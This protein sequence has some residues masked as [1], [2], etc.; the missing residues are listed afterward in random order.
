VRN[1]LTEL[2]ISLYSQA[3]DIICISETW[4]RVDFSDSL[5]DP[6]GEFTIFRK[7]RLSRDGGGVCIFVRRSLVSVVI[8]IRDA[9][10]SEVEIIGCS[11][12]VSGVGVKDSV[13][14]DV[15]CIYLPPNIS[16]ELFN[17]T[18]TYLRVVWNI[19]HTSL[20]TGDIN[21]PDFKWSP[22]HVPGG[23]RYQALH[24]V[25]TDLGCYQLNLNPTRGNNILD[26]L[27]CDEPIIVSNLV[28]T[29]PF[30]NSDHDCLEFTIILV[31]PTNNLATNSGLM[32]STLDWPKTDWNAFRMYCYN[33]SWASL[34]SCGSSNEC[35]SSFYN[36]LLAGVDQFVPTKWRTV[37]PVP[38][39]YRV[40]R[41]VR[42]LRI[43]KVLLWRAYRSNPSIDNLCKLKRCQALITLTINKDARAYEAKIIRS[44]SLTKFYKHVSSRL[45]HKSGIAPLRA[46]DG[47]LVMD[48]S[49]K[50]DILNMHFVSVGTV[51]NGLLPFLPNVTTPG[52][53]F[54]SVYF[55]DNII[56][57]IINKLKS[58]STPGPDGLS[59]RLLKNL[60]PVICG[61]L[62]M[63]FSLIANYG[64]IPDAWKA[65]TVIPIFKKGASSDPNN[66]RPISLTSVFCKVFESVLKSQ[67][68]DYLGYHSFINVAQ[69]GFLAKHS[70]TT[71]LLET[72]NDWTKLL[73]AK[74]IVKI[75]Y[76]DFAKAF[77]TVSIPKLLYKLDRYGVC[78]SALSLIKS[79]L[80]DRT[81]SVR[82][83]DCHSCKLTVANGCPQGSVLGPLLFTIFINDLPS[84]FKPDFKAKL[85]ADDLK[86]YS[87][88]DY[89]NN[90]AVA[91]CSL[92][93]VYAWSNEWQLQLALA[94]C[95]SMVLSRG[96]FEDDVNVLTIAGQPFASMDLVKDLGVFV[97]PKLSF[98]DH[99][100]TVI[101]KS[102]Q[103]IYLLFKCF[104]SRNID[105]MML[106]YTTY[107]LPLLEYCSPIWHPHK[108]ADIDRLEDV[109]RYFTK[110]LCGLW[111]VPYV[112]RLRRCGLQSLELRRTISDLVLC[113]KI[114]HKLIALNI[115]DFFV[116]DTNSV[117]RGHCFKMRIPLCSTNLR[118]TS[119]A[120]RVLPIWNALPAALV[121]P[122]NLSKFKR[123]LCIINL[124]QFLFRHHDV[125]ALT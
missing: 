40:S 111:D 96:A 24:Q 68:L 101:S 122:V 48:D 39:K 73:D 50:A 65:A 103:R 105:L 79:F 112:D 15:F 32:R 19:T 2:Y 20:I 106:A 59:A 72:T 14:L 109:Q 110:R 84:I 64:F 88:T 56:L 104:N 6:K 82:V 41:S 47:E 89:S 30:G 46:L 113:Y 9:L 45:T 81:Q 42:N 83:G 75:L 38:S 21:M 123:D 62:A 69:H 85:F 58:T 119:F 99:I 28:S 74:G 97:D 116:F 16:T 52:C 26:V 107:V 8:E 102:K 92:D 108:L 94:K 25:I 114:V 124:S 120:V 5:L 43:K 60:G 13:W 90:I 49:R 71:N 76:F 10:Y 35:W 100:D 44:G 27:L 93:A 98:S 61:P 12:S 118:Q 115:E 54:N 78:G 23:Y 86:A 95:G 34:L 53:E 17:L 66:Y 1:K 18:M 121:S 125:F 3:H 22:L 37:H 70:T 80:S 77:D 63:L 87:A 11:V 55:D 36:A 4:L 57:C 67:L 91:Q 51:D 117:T 29:A 7:D 31:A 33:L